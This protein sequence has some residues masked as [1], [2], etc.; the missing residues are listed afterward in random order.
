MFYVMRVT[1]M[2]S[3]VTRYFHCQVTIMSV[4]SI[5][6]GSATGYGLRATYGLLRTAGSLATATAVP[7]DIFF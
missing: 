6:S 3:E 2:R 5:E 1:M 7:R 4:V